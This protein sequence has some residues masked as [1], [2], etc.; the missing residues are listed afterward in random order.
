MRKEEITV[1]L[2]TAH[3]GTTAGKRS[4]DGRFREA[5]YSREIVSMVERRLRSMGYNVLV[6]HRPLDPAPE[7]LAETQSLQNSRELASRV[8]F[9]NRICKE[10][11]TNNCLY[12]SIHV[13][14]AGSGGA[15]MKAGGWSCYTSVGQTRGDKLADCM[16]E[17]ARRYLDGYA[18]IIE[19]GKK[20]GAYDRFQK[21]IRTDMSDGDPD[22]ESDFYVL[23]KTSCAACLTENLFQ[24]NRSDVTFLTSDEGKATISAIHVHG[25]SM[26]VDGLLK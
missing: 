14:A 10:R 6:D 13:N 16:Y 26:Y 19:Q 12:V 18:E 3:L 23:K 20:N 1:I 2:G 22:L 17:A 24:D 5:E 7:M 21:A 8:N 4:P 25:I 9:V 11:G 15:W